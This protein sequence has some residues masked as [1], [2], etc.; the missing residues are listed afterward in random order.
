[1]IFFIVEPNCDS[2]TKIERKRERDHKEIKVW[3]STK[4][5]RLLLPQLSVF[6]QGEWL[7]LYR[8]TAIKPLS[9]SCGGC[10]IFV[11]STVTLTNFLEIIEVVSYNPFALFY[12]L[13][14]TPPHSG[15]HRLLM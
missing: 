8:T 6:D 10:S 9:S 15:L 11:T 3:N 5:R 13:F 2:L 12:I 1:M 14:Y 4:V 7:C